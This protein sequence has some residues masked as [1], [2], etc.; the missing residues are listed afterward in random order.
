MNLKRFSIVGLI[1]A[2]VIAGTAPLA[3]AQTSTTTATTSPAVSAYL[4]QLQILRQLQQGMSG[5][6]I[7]TLQT[8]LSTQPDIYPEGLIT[9]FYGALTS[10]AV[11]KLQKKLGLPSVGR[12]GPM[13]LALINRSFS[14]DAVSYERKNGTTTACVKIPPGHLIAPG[15]LKKRGNQPLLIPI[16]QDL[17]S[18]IA[19][20]L[21]RIG[22]TT[23]TTTPPAIPAPVISSITAT[24]TATTTAT[25]SWACYMT[26]D[27][28]ESPPNLT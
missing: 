11:A 20:K 6:D 12:V 23:A 10:K 9:G 25:I 19:K 4:S 13:T 28:H 3:Y 22:T 27:N 21:G 18:G 8:Y 7:I 14:T 26:W 16:C 2:C 24:S 5:D 15:Q 17:P 1:A